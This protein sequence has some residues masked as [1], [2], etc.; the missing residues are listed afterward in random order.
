VCGAPGGGSMQWLPGPATVP[1]RTHR[2]GDHRPADTG[3]SGLELIEE[4]RQDFPTLKIIAISG[5]GAEFLNRA[6]QLGA[7]CGFEKPV[8]L[9]E[10]LTAV[11]ALV[12]SSLS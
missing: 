10:V 4:L 2:P 5:S 3:E 9:Q 1:C 8:H 12:P 6:K 7:H 11:E